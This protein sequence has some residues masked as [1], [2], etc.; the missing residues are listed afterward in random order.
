MSAQRNII[1]LGEP[2]TRR[3]CA[4]SRR[5]ALSTFH[6]ARSRGSQ[7]HSVGLTHEVATVRPS[8]VSVPKSIHIPDR[9]SRGPPAS[10][11][12][13]DQCALVH[14][15]EGG[16]KNIRSRSARH[17]GNDANCYET[18]EA[19]ARC[20][21]NCEQNGWIRWL[22]LFCR[23]GGCPYFSRDLRQHTGI[24]RKGLGGKQS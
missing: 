8:Q 15:Y 21:N 12:A 19:A 6:H 2:T 11:P 23:I 3:A 4:I 13:P 17:I 18:R 16:C 24:D 7:N 9:S 10:A 5:F 14:K 22:S 20:R 1:R